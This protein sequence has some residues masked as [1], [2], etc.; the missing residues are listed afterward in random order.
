MASIKNYVA[1]TDEGLVRLNEETSASFSD[2]ICW[3]TGEKNPPQLFQVQSYIWEYCYEFAHEEILNK[4]PPYVVSVVGLELDVEYSYQ[5]VGW[6]VLE[7][8]ENPS[9]CKDGIR[10]L[11]F[12]WE[13]SVRTIFKPWAF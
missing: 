12:R 6:R 11:E 4:Y 13:L 3:V 2:T 7:K 10:M 8:N 5:L 1:I 9:W